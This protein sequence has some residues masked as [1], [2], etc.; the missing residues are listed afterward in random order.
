M[1]PPG[2]TVVV[3]ASAG[4]GKTTRLTEELQRRL[5]DVEQPVAPERVV[6]VTYTRAAAATLAARV[7]LALLGA[8]Q[9]ALARR[10]AAARIG[11]VHSVCARFI[12]DYAL[13]LGLTPGARVLDDRLAEHAARLALE[14][15]LGDEERAAL[16]ELSDRFGGLD[17]VREVH[18]LITLARANDLDD[19][20][21]DR[22]V[23][24]SVA[25]L[26]ALLPT[27]GG[28]G[29]L[30]AELAPLLDLVL[31]APAPTSDAGKDERQR[32]AEVRRALLRGEPLAWPEWLD[33][34]DGPHHALRRF[35]AEHIA[36]PLLRQDLERATRLVFS[37]ARRTLG[38][39][40]DEKR[41]WRALDF[42]DQEVEA[43]RL[44]R[45][46]GVR[47]RLQDDIELVLVD[48]LQDTSPIE[49]AILSELSALARHSLFVGDQK[50]AIFGFR[51]TDPR[52][53]QAVTEQI[54]T[55]DDVL[56]VCYR[57][58][59]GLV[60]LT[61][62]LFAPAF[63]R[64]GLAPARVKAR[65]SLVDEPPGLGQ[66]LERWTLTPGRPLASEIA[67]GIA[68]LLEDAE[69]RVRERGEVVEVKPGHVAV[70]ARTNAFA[71]AI[72]EQLSQLG[73]ASCL[74]RS[75]LSA[76]L[77]ARALVAGLALFVDGRDAPASATIARL[78]RGAADPNAWLAELLAAPRGQAFVEEPLV[79][80]V[81]E[82]AQAHRTAGVVAAVD[83]VVEALRLR[84]V[85]VAWG[86]APQRLANLGALRALAVR[87]VEEQS[88][89]GLGATVPGLLA[90]LDELARAGPGRDDDEDDRQGMV[91]APDSVQLV[92][93]H[94]AKGSEWPVVVLTG[95]NGGGRASAFGAHVESDAA[96]V[97]L[98]DPLRARRVR[99]WPKPYARRWQGGL[100][101]V[102]EAGA[103]HRALL[104]RHD[105]EELRLLYVGF[106]RARDRLVLVG[107]PP[108][109][110]G[111]D[112]WQGKS[113]LLRHLRAG[114]APLLSEPEERGRASWAG[115]TVDVKLRRPRARAA[116]PPLAGRASVP[117][118][119]APA[120][121]P[122]A[123][124][125]PSSLTGGGAAMGVD[126]LGGPLA[127]SGTPTDD[128][129]THLGSAVHAFL[130]ADWGIDE[131]ARLE[132]AAAV[133]SRFEVAWLL[134][135]SSLVAI[136]RRL[137]DGLARRFPG[138]RLARER[139][140]RRRLKNGS[141]VRGQIDLV[142][143]TPAGFA[144]VD[145][146]TYLGVEDV[147]ATAASFAGQLAAYG[148]ALAA[149]TGRPVLALL[150]HLP[151]QGALVEISAATS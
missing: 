98:A 79:R 38:R 115:Q 130:A 39:Y 144:V 68:E 9:P 73:V 140:I 17:W 29:Q 121:Y 106:T 65:A 142:V 20:A 10:L 101:E 138:A 55:G 28:P 23:E 85:C 133:L 61:S 16:E 147:A 89:R 74:R 100:L 21:L 49:L 122:P 116:V 4:T 131:A 107:P 105:E 70:L 26:S 35:G 62:A 47:A 53:M 80:A 42:V 128:D 82:A 93:W 134:D 141:V 51:G 76:T 66:V 40:R 24:A 44:L 60:A 146:K 22:S 31:A 72:A 6:A 56:D 90:R 97:D 148:D 41:R 103:T 12:D 102:A 88:A 69:V 124:V 135:A 1:N 75:G 63:A 7:R 25:S 125:Q 96:R 118:A 143:E 11:T 112:L 43:L 54:A 139:P 52:L 111:F 145:H 5:L 37:V 34:G 13:E 64:H 127:L 50:Q 150:V 108:G 95:L 77:E 33:F 14:S 132:L 48:E 126:Q 99:Y 30:E 81:V 91:A 94:K 92:T 3:A 45:D 19:A 149:A 86:D 114:D 36:H 110:Q 67:A 32:L 113:S 119:L 15:E 83:V 123:F 57:S 2:R 129:M 84:E 8:G 136:G 71:R 87:F 59:P 58:R 78:T 104:G 18:Q 117:R 109:H 46:R 120:S 151:L 137:T 27:P